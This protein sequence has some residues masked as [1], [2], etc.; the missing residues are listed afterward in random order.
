[1]RLDHIALLVASAERSAA[2]LRARG[3]FVGGVKIGL[4]ELLR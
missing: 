2:V 3:F 4:E 1:M